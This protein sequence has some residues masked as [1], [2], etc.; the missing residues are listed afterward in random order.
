MVPIEHASASPHGPICDESPDPISD[1]M[2][3]A[4]AGDGFSTYAQFD[5]LAF[6]TSD[7]IERFPLVKSVLKELG[8][9]VGDNCR[10]PEA[11]RALTRSATKA[12]AEGRKILIAPEGDLAT[13]G[14]HFR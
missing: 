12:K 3:L 7:H 2:L 6:V 13:V 14:V 5:D 9:I 8:A 1:V 11:R 10:G 4:G